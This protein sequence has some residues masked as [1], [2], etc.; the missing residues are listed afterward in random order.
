MWR[1]PGEIAGDGIDNEGNGF[2]DDVFGIDTCNDDSDPFD[3]NSHG[4][5]VAG[6][7]GATGDNATGVVGVNWDVQL[8][9]LKFLCGA[10][11]GALSDAIDAI[12]YMT[13]MK[14]QFGV[15]VVVS[16]NSW[17]GGGFSQPLLDAINASIAADILFVAAA[18]NAANDNDANA[19]F[20]ATYASEGIISVAATNDRDGLAG[21]SNFGLTTVDLGAPGVAVLS[22]FPGNTYGLN[23]GTSMASPHVAGAAALLRG[24]NPTLDLLTIKQAI[25]DGAEPV[26]SLA[27]RVVTGGRLNLARSLS[28]IPAATGGGLVPT[29]V[30]VV[31]SFTGSIADIEFD[32]ATGVLHADTDGVRSVRGRLQTID[33]RTVGGMPTQILDAVST[34][35]GADSDFEVT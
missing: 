23:T 1:N 24:F 33:L 26:G 16:N 15:N 8:M 34:L 27:G 12:N 32:S 21:F 28:L 9:A 11:F 25:L 3:D 7:I 6:T 13:M 4:T 31:G 18:G 35:V 30:T 29:G 19:T 17:G 10:G 2:V 5:H 14:T 20:P 22:T